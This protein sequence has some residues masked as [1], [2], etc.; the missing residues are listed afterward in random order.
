M[1]CLKAF[2]ANESIGGAQITA[3]GAFSSAELAFFD[4]EARSTFP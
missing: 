1:A 2:A 3:I 4:W